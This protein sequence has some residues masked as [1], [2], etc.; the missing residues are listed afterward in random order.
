M[1]VSYW[2][3]K[4]LMNELSQRACTKFYVCDFVK[5]VFM[6]R[7]LVLQYFSFMALKEVLF[8]IVLH[9]V[10]TIE[11]I[12]VPNFFRNAMLMI[13]CTYLVFVFGFTR[14]QLTML[15]MMTDNTSGNRL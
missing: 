13:F 2:P 6:S 7:R 1:F 10:N 8:S 11:V 4:V 5:K 15:T 9:S 14:A 3:L 12:P